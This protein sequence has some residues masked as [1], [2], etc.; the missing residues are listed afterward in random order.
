MCV[1]V[2]GGGGGVISLATT[3]S[4][5][6]FA[7]YRST[8]GPSDFHSASGVRGGGGLEGWGVVIQDAWI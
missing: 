2:C 7:F 5:I 3:L 8:C 4:F 1:C 6:T